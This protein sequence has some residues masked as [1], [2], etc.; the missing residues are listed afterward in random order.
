MGNFV[1][2][3]KKVAEAFD[4]RRRSIFYWIK[5]GMP[6][7]Q[8]SNRKYRYDLDAIMAWKLERDNGR[9]GAGELVDPKDY[10]ND[11]VVG[12]FKD[13]VEGYRIKR[14]DIFAAKQLESL[15]QQHRIRRLK[16]SELSDDDI[17]K[18]DEKQAMAWFSKLGM[19]VAIFYDK[20]ELERSKGVDD[21]NKV[22]DAIMKIKEIQRG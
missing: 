1:N 9:D 2:S 21:V 15:E 7:E 13:K 18:M 5:D 3:V 17:R 11:V 16:L 22:L 19:D 14:G 10:R 20:E 8:L 6:R 12:E 4:T